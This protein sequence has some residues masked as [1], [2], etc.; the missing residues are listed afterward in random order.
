MEILEVLLSARGRMRQWGGHFC[1]KSIGRGGNRNVFFFFKRDRSSYFYVKGSV[2]DY[3]CSRNAV[4]N[5]QKVPPSRSIA[6]RTSR[7]NCFRTQRLCFTTL[8]CIS[9]QNRMSHGFRQLAR[10]TYS[11]RY[12][13]QTQL[14]ILKLLLPPPRSHQWR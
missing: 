8:S 12:A 1:S 9:K 10:L 2:V 13:L 7:R 5:V 4:L 11:A 3:V 14:S 6:C